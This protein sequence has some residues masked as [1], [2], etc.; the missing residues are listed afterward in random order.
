[1]NTR[2]LLLA[3]V[4][5]AG[6]ASS[7]A[8]NIGEAPSPGKTRAQVIQEL[9]DAKA[10]GEL[11]YSDVDYPKLPAFKSTKTRA[12][13]I[14]ETKQAKAQGLLDYNDADYPRQREFKSELTRQEVMAE[15]AYYQQHLDPQ[16]LY[17][18]Q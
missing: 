8:Q 4:L 7:Y 18:G 6:T 14:E 17:G 3:A 15:A 9:V 5:I 12:Q 11:N 10:S 1:M 13:V 16:N 2:H